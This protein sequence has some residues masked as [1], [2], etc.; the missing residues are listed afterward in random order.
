MQRIV[1]ISID[2]GDAC[3]VPDQRYRCAVDGAYC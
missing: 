2:D 1:A 3:F